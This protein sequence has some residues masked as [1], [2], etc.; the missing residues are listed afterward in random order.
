MAIFYLGAAE[1]LLPHFIILAAFAIFAGQAFYAFKRNP[2][3]A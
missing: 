1:S 2:N 3:S